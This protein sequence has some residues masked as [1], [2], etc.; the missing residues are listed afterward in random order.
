MRS[1]LG[2]YNDYE[3]R[4]IKDPSSGLLDLSGINFITP[5]VLLPSLHFAIENSLKIR[6]NNQTND[7]EESFRF[8]GR[9]NDNITFRRLPEDRSDSNNYQLSLWSC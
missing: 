9:T 4:V 3:Q 1:L 6:V 5:T 7:I 8:S 2:Y